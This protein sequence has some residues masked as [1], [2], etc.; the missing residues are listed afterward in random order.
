M[1]IPAKYTARFINGA[2]FK[3]SDWGDDGK[4]I[5]RIA[6]LTGSDFDNFYDGEI[7]R[8]YEIED[9]DLL[10]SWSATLDSFVWNRGPALLNQHIFKVMP[11]DN[12]YKGFLYYSL[13]HYSSI[14][15]DMDAHGSTMRHIK[16]ESL[17]NKIWL[18]DFETQRAITKFLDAETARVDRLID[19]NTQFSALVQ[20]R[21]TAKI[22]A[23]ILG[24]AG[25]EGEWLAN[26]PV[27]WKAER[28]KFHFREAQDRSEN[29][30]E[31]L[32][33]VSH[34]T[35]VTKRADKDVNM[36]L[37]NSNEGYKLVEPG[38]LV[39]NTMWAWMGAMGVSPEYGLISP[40][41]GVY[42]PY[43]DELRP[44][45]VDLLV[46]SKPFVAEATRR[47]KGIHSSRLRLYPD[48]F[49]D[50]RLP[51]PPLQQQDEI[52]REVASTTAREIDLLRKTNRAVSLL[53][54]HRAALITAAVTGQIDV[55]SWDKRG[56][57]ER[58]FDKIGEAI[59]A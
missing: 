38:D 3:P 57:F 25:N 22:T 46:R 32:L 37:A 7:D 13:K 24:G 16:K 56:E 43:S 48:A 15:A 39:I 21:Q 2:P 55:T 49:L 9:G 31:E 1:M 51:V 33:T 4:P 12:T 47:S 44:A 27:H 28:A 23:A 11:F 58:R 26:L 30:E 36:F 29:G 53:R 54:E 35:G 20:E 18:P 17:G 34:I 8:R 45:F 19:K 10:F 41:Y 40:S 50:M 6:Q 59:S 52:M 42:R 14:W 5:V